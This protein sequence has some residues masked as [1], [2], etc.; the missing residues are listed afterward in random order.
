MKIHPPIRGNDIHGSGEYGAP[1]G[2]RT[3]KGID[4]ACYAGSEIESVCDGKITKIGYP[5]NPSDAK[6]GHL[7]YVQVTDGGGYDVR[8]FYCLPLHDLKVG[9]SVSKGEKVAQSQG[10][11]EIY[12]GI[13]DH[14]HFEVKYQGEH[15]NPYDYLNSIDEW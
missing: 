8:Y 10:L 14:F 2:S 13:T 11:L 1:R 3:H 6:K 7:R 12:P 5:Y 4:I 15:Q 9:D